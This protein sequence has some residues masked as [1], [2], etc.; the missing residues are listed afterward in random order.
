MWCNGI[1]CGPILLFWTTI[2]GDLEAIRNFPFLLSPGFQV[3]MLLSCIM[4]FLINY[5]VFMNTTLNSALTQT[6]CGNLKDLFTI[7]FGWILFG[8][9]PCCWPVPRFLWILLVCLLQTERAIN[10]ET[11]A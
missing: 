3:V 2:R 4:A 5:F 6:I 7:G 9:L 11:A 8:G 10:A 1:I